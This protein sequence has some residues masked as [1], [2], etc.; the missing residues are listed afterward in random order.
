MAAQAAAAACGHRWPEEPLPQERATPATMHEQKPHDGFLILTKAMHRQAEITPLKT[1]PSSKP[2]PT[3]ISHMLV[4]MHI[5]HPPLPYTGQ[6]R[7]TPL[8][9]Q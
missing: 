9:K 7:A 3:A 8:K 4:P 5:V 1:V 2:K 6:R